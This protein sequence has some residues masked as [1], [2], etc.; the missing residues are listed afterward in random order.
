VS[1]TT[2]VEKIAEKM[3]TQQRRFPQTF[4]IPDAMAIGM[5][6]AYVDED[7]DGF[8]AWTPEEQ[9]RGVRNVLAALKLAEQKLGR[10]TTA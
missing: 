2:A 7:D 1:T 5:I 6:S 10:V 4:G 9:L 8:S 3:L